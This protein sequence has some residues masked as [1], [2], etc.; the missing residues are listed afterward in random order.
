MVVNTLT[1]YALPLTSLD[2]VLGVQWLE[3]LG[4]VVCD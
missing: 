2:L 3:K 4:A 1:L